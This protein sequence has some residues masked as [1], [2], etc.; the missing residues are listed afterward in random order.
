[1][2]AL[3]EKSGPGVLPLIIVDEIPVVSGRYPTRDEM[4]FWRMMGAMPIQSV[5]GSGCCG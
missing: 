5:C 2:K 4:N 1:V 3:L